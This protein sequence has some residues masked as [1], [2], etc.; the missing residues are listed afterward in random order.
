M[1]LIIENSAG[2]A[3]EYNREMYLKIVFM[4]CVNTVNEN[5]V[6]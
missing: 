1:V 3:F 6:G 2:N 5:K 4:H